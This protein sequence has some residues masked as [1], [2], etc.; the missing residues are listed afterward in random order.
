[1]PRTT[2][3]TGIPLRRPTPQEMPAVRPEKT[4]LS[5]WLAGRRLNDPQQISAALAGDRG[6]RELLGKM[7]GPTNYTE[8]AVGGGLS[9]LLGVQLRPVLKELSP[10]EASLALGFLSQLPVPASVKGWLIR[11]VFADRDGKAKT[12]ALA[13]VDRYGYSDA[14]LA[15]D[16]SGDL[17]GPRIQ[18][19]R[20]FDEFDSGD[21]FITR[22]INIKRLDTAANKAKTPEGLLAALLAPP[23]S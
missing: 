1:M 9:Y 10:P 4:T 14:P 13:F 19:L 23:Q 6:V 21:S 22:L 7:V 20:I 8:E 5:D 2:P 15:G 16:D 3:V 18:L 12:V 17:P 11:G